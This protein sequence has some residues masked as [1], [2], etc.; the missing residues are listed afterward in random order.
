[1]K[2]RAFALIAALAT[3]ALASADKTPAD[4][5]PTNPPT[6]NSPGNGVAHPMQAQPSTPSDPPKQ[7]GDTKNAKL[8]DAEVRVIAR[9]HHVN[10]MEINLGKEAEKSGTARIRDYARTVVSDHQSADKDLTAFAK[11]H[12]LATIP[13]DKPMTDAERQDEKDMT[14]AMAHLKTLKGADF[15]KEFLKIS[16]TSHEKELARIDSAMSSVTDPDLKSLLQAVKPM[17][18]RHADQA[19]DLLKSPQAAIDP[20]KPVDHLPSASH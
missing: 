1:M 12:K 16:V 9:L 20:N 14:T 11:A 4:S 15:D 8:S 13:A 18:Q 17:L 7:G 3:P 10:Q 6:N 2:L 5:P 19:R